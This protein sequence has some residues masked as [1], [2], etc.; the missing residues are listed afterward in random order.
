MTDS[1][2]PRPIGSL[3]VPFSFNN[4]LNPPGLGRHPAYQ[5]ANVPALCDLQG[6]AVKEPARNKTFPKIYSLLEPAI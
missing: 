2:C 3:S 5:T 6:R 4:F 1:I